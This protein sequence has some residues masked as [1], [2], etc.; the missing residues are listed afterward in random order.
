MIAWTNALPAADFD[1]L[2]V[3]PSDRVFEA[4]VAVLVEVCLFGAFRCDKALPAAVL[5]LFPVDLLLKVLEAALAALLRVT[6]SLAIDV[7]LFLGVN[8]IYNQ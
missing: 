6:F 5:D 3:R 1:D 4:A 7:P 8:L 2:D